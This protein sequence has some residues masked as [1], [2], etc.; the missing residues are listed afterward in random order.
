ML[1]A[2]ILNKSEKVAVKIFSFQNRQIL[3]IFRRLLV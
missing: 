2:G 1:Q 3:K